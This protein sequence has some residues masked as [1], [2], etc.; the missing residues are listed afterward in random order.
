MEAKS[1]RASPKPVVEYAPALILRK[2]SAKGL[3]ET[4]KRIKEQI[5]DGEDI[6]GEFADLAEIRPKTRSTIRTATGWEVNGSFDGEVFFPKPS[7]DEQRR[8]VDKI[9]AASGV[10][11]QGP[12]GTGKSHTIANLICHLLATGQRTLITAK[13]PR[14]L[15][16]LEGLVPDELRPLCINLLGS[17]LEERRSLESSVGGILR[18]KEE[19]NED[20][21]KREREN[22]KGNSARCAR[23]RRRSIGGSATSGNPKRIRSPSRKE[24]IEAQQPELLKPSTGIGTTMNGS[25]M[26]SLRTRPA[27]SLKVICGRSCSPSPFHSRNTARIEP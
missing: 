19:W 26:P 1:V 10:L 8:I 13:T 2:R 15:Q 27:R 16:V 9:R 3:T 6:P 22:L 21:A 5:E 7:N 23:R 12:P 25:Q 17:G 18:K 20:Q 4:F 14:A 11:V 24:P